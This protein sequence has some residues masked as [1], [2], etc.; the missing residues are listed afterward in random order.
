MDIKK[1]ICN[2]VVLAFAIF[3]FIGMLTGYGFTSFEYWQEIG[4]AFADN[5]FLGF[6]FVFTPITLIALMLLILVQIYVL[7]RQTNLVKENKFDKAFA[8]IKSIVYGIAIV[9]FLCTMPVIFLA[10]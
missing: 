6:A 3:S 9:S 7:L 1:I 4:D 10:L 5:L 2:S 8:I